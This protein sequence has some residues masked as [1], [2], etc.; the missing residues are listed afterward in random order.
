M[1]N[2]NETGLKIGVAPETLTREVLVPAIQVRINRILGIISPTD[3]QRKDGFKFTMAF[4]DT[5]GIAAGSMGFYYGQ[6]EDDSGEM[7]EFWRFFGIP[8]SN[9]EELFI[10]GTGRD[11]CQ[12]F[13]LDW[14][15]K[16][17]I[18]E[19]DNEM[20]YS[21]WDVAK[22]NDGRVSPFRNDRNAQEHI[23]ALI[24]QFETVFNSESNT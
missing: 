15:P 14:N 16:Y 13:T 12:R 5:N 11:A 1:A 20:L 4:T 7:L 18:R 9:D 3:Q 8:D 21:E 6:R 10:E 23:D 17:P 2:P 19:Y 24:D 22:E